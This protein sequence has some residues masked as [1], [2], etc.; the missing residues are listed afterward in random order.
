MKMTKLQEKIRMQQ[1]FRTI[2]LNKKEEERKKLF[3]EWDAEY[4]KE[5]EAFE[6]FMDEE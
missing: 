1:V 4:E 5:R 3:K 2:H 6:K